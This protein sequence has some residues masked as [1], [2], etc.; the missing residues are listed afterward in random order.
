M[1]KTRHFKDFLRQIYIDFGLILAFFVHLLPHP[2]LLP[3]HQKGFV[4]RHFRRRVAVWQQILKNKNYCCK[5]EK[6]SQG[7]LQA[8]SSV[9]LSHRGAVHVFSRISHRD[10]CDPSCVLLLQVFI[11]GFASIQVIIGHRSSC[12]KQTKHYV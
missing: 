1:E 2:T 5:K 12:T 11:I 8:R 4:Q 3:P 10:T 7:F 9:M 6:T